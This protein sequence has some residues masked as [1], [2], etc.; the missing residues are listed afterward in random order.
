MALKH[1]SPYPHGPV[2]WP[3]VGGGT[4]ASLSHHPLSFIL[5]DKYSK[6]TQHR[7]HASSNPL[8]QSGRDFPGFLPRFI[9][10]CSQRDFPKSSFLS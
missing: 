2:P 6:N 5:F 4:S 7:P 8:L 10:E 1:G 9:I 3:L